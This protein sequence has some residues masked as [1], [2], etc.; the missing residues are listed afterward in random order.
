VRLSV[1]V[2]TLDEE[3]TLA[4]T[5]TR[6]RVCG[7]HEL[8][9]VDGGSRDATCEVAARDA[10]RVLRAP[11]GRAS[12][13]NAGA[14]AASGDVLLFVHADTLV[15]PGYADAIARALA[16]P[17][18][19][20]GRFDVRF[21]GAGFL[22]WLVATGMNLRSRWTR[23]ATGDQAI[24]VRR[25]AFEALGG[26]PQVPLFEDVRLAVALKRH[27]G[28]ACLHERVVTSARRWERRG[29]MRTV[30]LMWGLRLGHALGIAPARLQRLY[31]DVR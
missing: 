12:Q 18:T 14:A 23:I 27:G 24:F 9:V 13:M 16:D 6:V 3:A 15:P 4:T 21:E 8:L 11:A 5:L 22:L 28:I 25:A 17:A 29:V 19:V 2:P 10:D 26:Y 1:I 30:L 7:V 31:A 20:G